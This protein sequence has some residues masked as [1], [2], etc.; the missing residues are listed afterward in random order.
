MAGPNYL[1]AKREETA[2]VKFLANTEVPP[3]IPQFLTAHA[4]FG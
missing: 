4:A 1:L 3:P 2:D